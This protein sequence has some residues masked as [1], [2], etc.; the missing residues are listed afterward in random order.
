M[1]F[2]TRF[3]GL[4]SA[5]T[6]SLVLALLFAA[7][8][9]AVIATQPA[10]AASPATF[11]VGSASA[12]I[13]PENPQFVGGYGFMVGPTKEVNDNLEVRAF[14]VGKGDNAAAFVSSDL[15]GWFSAYRGPL[16]EPYGVDR[17]REKIADKLGDYG[18]D[19]GRESVIVSTTHVH[20]APTVTG[21]WGNPDPD[22]LKQVSEA[23]VSAVD[24][25]AS[26]AK[27]SE[28]WTGTGNIRSFVWQN[29]QGT[30]HPDGFSVDE[31]LPVM[32][33]RDPET[34]ATNGLY[35]TVPNHPDQ[36]QA[37]ANDNKMS[38]DW[39]GYTRRQ[40]DKLNGGTSVIAAGTL[41]RQEPPGSVKTYDEVIQQGKYVVNA[42]QRAMATATPLTGSRI[43]GSERYMRFEADNEDLL[44]GI[45]LFNPPTGDCIEAFDICTIPR[46][47]EPPYQYPGPLPGDDPDVGTHTSAIRIGDALYVTNPGEAFPEI[48][49][50][51]RDSVQGARTVNPVGLA[52]DFLGY[53]YE[54]ADYTDEQF[55]SSDFET[56]NI[57]EDMPQ[58]NLDMARENAEELGFST[59]DQTIHAEFDSDVVDRPGIQ[60]YPD[61]VE[62]DNPTVNLYGATARSQ[63][64]AVQPDGP[65]EWDFGDGTTG[66]SANQD[67]FDHT[68][69]GPGS[70]DVTATITGTNA[71]TRSWTDTIM[72]DPPLKASATQVKRDSGGTTLK[73]K[74]TGGS[75]KLIGGRWTCSDGKKRSGHKIECPGKRAGKVT[76]VASDGAGNTA[77]TSIKV[78]PLKV[79]V[80][81]PAKSRKGKKA[82]YRVKV[83]NP[84]GTKVTGLRLKI[85]GRGVSVNTS[86][87]KLAAGKGKTV[88]IK[89]RFRK[90]GKIKAKF[91][92]SSKNGG[93]L[94]ATKKI[95]VKG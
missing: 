78:A 34:G 2:N 23:A 77:Q 84:G 9:I 71:K 6:V 81:G 21:I 83:S 42:V 26:K 47:V 15:V 33:A 54:R 87:G 59:T 85:S 95:R 45:K 1:S 14:V 72:I 31:K 92:V 44:L 62:S 32:W 80:K 24:Q 25:A 76:V 68:F 74:T 13:N 11:K 46:S 40:L 30:N 50:A 73:V 53:Y 48:N 27:T 4:L 37:S 10:L 94:S 35:A 66:T 63:D 56:Y 17:T 39:P 38:A 93:S 89:V 41:G 90:P 57:S 19:I 61:T 3:A 49:D 75:G 88:K 16:L 82:T 18:Y 43:N 79:K 36:F 91:K 86:V 51:I 60:W 55:G 70:Y 52:G 28:I 64:N 65:I 7:V 8:T 20:A 67:R 29:G 22:Y 5:R 12:S 58:M 69:P